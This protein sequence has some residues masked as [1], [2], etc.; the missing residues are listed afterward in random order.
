MGW[1]AVIKTIA[2]FAVLGYAAWSDLK[3]REVDDKAWVILS[4]IAIPLTTLEVLSGHLAIHWLLL[5]MLISFVIGL[6]VYVL[7]LFGGADA[8]ALWCLGVA[9]P[10]YPSLKPLIVEPLFPVQHP[11]FPVSVFNNMLV[12]AALTSVYVL[13]RNM[14]YKLRGGKLFDGYEEPLRRKVLAILIGYKV[15]ALKLSRGSHV[16]LMEER[17]GGSRK[18]KLGKLLAAAKEEELGLHGDYKPDEELWVTPALPM[19]V[20]M[21]IGLIL[22]LLLGDLV[23]LITLVI[24]SLAP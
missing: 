4:L 7:G 8:K 16:F 14:T 23:S 19:L 22:A 11:F 2:V 3:Y 24:M 1:E 20:Y 6:L 9:L 15:K 12:L 10:V 21:F 13:V 18:L 5:S 17:V